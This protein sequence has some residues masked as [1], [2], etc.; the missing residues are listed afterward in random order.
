MGFARKLLG[1]LLVAAL[2]SAVAVGG[3]KKAR[4]A[5]ASA[6]D[7]GEDEEDK[8]NPAVQEERYRDVIKCGSCEKAVKGLVERALRDPLG[9][10]VPTGMNKRKPLS[11]REK[12]TR[13]ARAID[14]VEGACDSESGRELI[15]CQDAVGRFEDE[16]VELVAYD[17]AH[18]KYAKPE[19]LCLPACEYKTSMK[20]QM[21]EMQANIRKLH[22]KPLLDEVLALFKDYW[23][24]WALLF[25]TVFVAA[26]FVNVM[27]VRRHSLARHRQRLEAAARAKTK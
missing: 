7:D 11:Q 13:T 18:P 9:E 2:L 20:S 26:A 1:V 24:V 22:E 16:M 5:Q 8:N 27:L 15:Y 12:A 4:R 23:H 14:I 6:V 17:G 21:E 19:D 10:V 3:K 25:V